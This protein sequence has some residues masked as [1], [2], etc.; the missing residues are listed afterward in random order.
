MRTFIFCLEDFKAYKS[1]PAVKGMV[2]FTVQNKKNVKITDFQKKIMISKNQP[3]MN[4][5]KR[6]NYAH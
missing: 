1:P 3:V 2:D 4:V 6:R 5:Q